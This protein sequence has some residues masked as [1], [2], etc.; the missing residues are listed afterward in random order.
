ME[1]HRLPEIINSQFSILNCPMS[2]PLPLPPGACRLQ[3]DLGWTLAQW[4]AGIT[5]RVWGAAPSL[6]ELC[7][8]G[9]EYALPTEERAAQWPWN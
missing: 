6:W 4:G 9:T 7:A 8:Y 3:P 2:P 5:W 1:H